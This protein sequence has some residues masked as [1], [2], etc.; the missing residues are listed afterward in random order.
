MRKKAVALLS[1]ALV[2]VLSGCCN[3]ETL[4]K[5]DSPGK[6]VAAVLCVRDCGATTV[7]HTSITL[8]NNDGWFGAKK[9]IFV[10]KYDQ[11]VEMQEQFRTSG[12]L[13]CMQT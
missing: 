4:A 9:T 11:R 10:T 7:E 2:L 6:S 13:S 1:T 5:T 8:K 3:E 12:L